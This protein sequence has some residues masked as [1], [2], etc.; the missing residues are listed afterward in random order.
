MKINLT[1]FASVLMEKH[2]LER[3]EAQYFIESFVE[4]IHAG[5]ERD[6]ILKLKGLGTFKVLRVSARESI[7]VNTGER[8]LIDSHPKLSFT[9]DAAMKE[10]VNRPFSQ[11]ETVAINEGVVFDDMPAMVDDEDS[12]NDFETDPETV[13]KQEVPLVQLETNTEIEPEIKPQPV[14][15]VEERL[16]PVIDE[17]PQPM[18]EEKTEPLAA[19]LSA[20]SPEPD[21]ET[22]FPWLWVVFAALAGLLIGYL[23]G[24]GTASPSDPMIAVAPEVADTIDVQSAGS[25]NSMLESVTGNTDTLS[26]MPVSD[27]A[28]NDQAQSVQENSFDSEKYDEMD[29]RVRLGAYSIIGVQEVAKARA[30]ETL[31]QI[32]RRYLGPDMECYVEVLNNLKASQKLVEGQEI[33]IPKLEY[34]KHLRKN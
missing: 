1:D 21:K 9:P 8:V 3:R 16:E 14:S 28:I 12:D 33:K 20:T 13:V 29:S 2:G 25:D 27:N 32:S 22:R 24:R 31:R 19:S 18:V 23:I 26:E 6:K 10:L 4:T 17:T 7:N 11:F 34:K 5:L 30:G 15:E